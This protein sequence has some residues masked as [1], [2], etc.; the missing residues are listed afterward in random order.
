M[1]VPGRINVHDRLAYRTLTRSFVTWIT[2]VSLTP[3]VVCAVVLGYQFQ[4]AYRTRVLAHMEQLVLKHKQEINFFLRDCSAELRMLSDI[5]SL[6]E[7]SND[8]FLAKVLG[9]LR[10]EHGGVFEDIGFL[11]SAGT[12]LAYAGPFHLKNANYADAGWFQATKGQEV[13]ISD[14]FLGRRGLPHFVVTVRCTFAGHPYLLRAT[15]M[16]SAF[17]D[18]VQNL[19]HGATAQA[20]IIN[21]DG[22]FQTPP[23]KGLRLDIPFLR[24]MVWGG[25][26]GRPGMGEDEV[27][28][29]SHQDAFSGQASLL[30][31]TPLQGGKWALV[32]QEDEADALAVL[33]RS[34]LLA[35][36]I[37]LL[38]AMAIL[39]VSTI[40]ARRLVARIAAADAARDALND[41]IIAAGKLASVGEL[42]AGVA[43]EINNPVA[44]M[45]EEAGWICDIL[46]GDAPAAPENVAEMRRALHQIRAQGARCRDVTHKLLSFAHKADSNVRSVDCNDLVSEI[47][48]LSARRARYAGVHLRTDLAPGL[49]PAAGL[50]SELQ[51]ILLNLMNNALDAMESNGGELTIAT[52]PAGARVKLSVTD[53]GHGIPAAVLPRIFEPF[54]TTKAVGK[55]T[56]LGLSICA[57]IIKKLDGEITVTS[58]LEKGSTFTVLLPAIAADAGRE[59]PHAADKDAD[60]REA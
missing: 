35:L 49:P 56:G 20:C 15:I 25:P 27:A 10:A 18:L 30:V 41:Q 16:F 29:F 24:K 48:E 52:R 39:A 57:D 46:S 4:S 5:A 3:L 51:Q 50:P 19:G 23:K 43:H 17:T 31:I 44:I 8:A 2:A 40:L 14:V 55:G 11:D 37:V 22:E 34:R 38:G 26:S 54:F 53:T 9:T 32:Y 42:A 45:T 36:T 47:A 28:T 6:N 13:S 1:P 21:A 33:Y 59:E 7:L 58:E 60:H 12:M